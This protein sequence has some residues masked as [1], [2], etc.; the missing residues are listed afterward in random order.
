MRYHSIVWNDFIDMLIR[1]PDAETE[2]KDKDSTKEAKDEAGF[3]AWL[4]AGN[5]DD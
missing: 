5:S 2:D 1:E 3:N 4:A